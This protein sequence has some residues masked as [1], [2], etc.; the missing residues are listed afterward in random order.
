MIETA[1]SLATNSLPLDWRDLP[2]DACIEE[3]T[4]ERTPSVPQGSYKA[5]GRFPVV[6]QGSRLIAGYT[7]DANIVHSLLS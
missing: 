3:G 5:T 1:T 6:D 4:I 2:F 7:D